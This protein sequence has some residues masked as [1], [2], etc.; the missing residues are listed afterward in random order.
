MADYST[1]SQKKAS[2]DPNPS[3]RR[4]TTGSAGEAPP[5]SSQDAKAACSMARV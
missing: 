4:L 3:S 2:V 5:H 1:G